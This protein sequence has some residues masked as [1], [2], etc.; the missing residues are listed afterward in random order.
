METPNELTPEHRAEKLEAI[1]EELSQLVTKHGPTHLAR[2][3]KALDANHAIL[4]C[5][6][7]LIAE[8]EALKCSKQTTE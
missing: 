5:I 8:N 7:A 3:M 1:Y 6:K 2:G 4:E